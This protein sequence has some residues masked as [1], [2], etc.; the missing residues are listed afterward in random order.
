M[1]KG[2]GKLASSS[3][4]QRWGRIWIV[5][6]ILLLIV[7]GLFFGFGRAGLL[8]R[9]SAFTFA[10]FGLWAAGS[11]V[12]VL[13][14]ALAALAKALEAIHAISVRILLFLEMLE[15]KDWGRCSI[16]LGFMPHRLSIPNFTRFQHSLALSRVRFALFS[17]SIQPLSTLSFHS[18]LIV[19]PSFFV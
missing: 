1:V 15:K 7:F 8:D 19:L 2:D 18:P 5:C 12:F 4:K 3:Y 13:W 16:V 6:A 11:I 10:V 9:D 17:S 14:T